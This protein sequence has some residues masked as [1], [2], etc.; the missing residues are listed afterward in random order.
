MAMEQRI[1]AAA[2]YA[3]ISQA[4][5]ARRIKMT[6][7]NFNQKLKRET[8]TESELKVINSTTLKLGLFN[9]SHKPQRLNSCLSWQIWKA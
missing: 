3:G 2:A 8:F 5:L 6:P 7:S 9:C 1:K 4:E